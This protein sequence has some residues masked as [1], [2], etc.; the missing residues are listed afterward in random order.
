MWAQA[1]GSLSP[2]LLPYN[3]PSLDV[4]EELKVNA[5][6]NFLLYCTITYCTVL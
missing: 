1:W 2:I 6:K 4:T 3:K 5:A